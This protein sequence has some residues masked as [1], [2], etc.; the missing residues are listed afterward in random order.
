MHSYGDRY[1][2][3]FFINRDY[4]DVALLDRMFASLRAGPQAKE[5]LRKTLA[6]DEDLF[7]KAL[8]KLWIHKGVV[9]D[10]AENVVRGEESWRASYLLQGEQK[11]AQIDQMMRFAE[12][13]SCR[14]NSLVRHF[15][16]T[17]TGASACGLCDFCA[18]V[19]CVAQRFRTATDTE[20]SALSRVL[21][22]LRSS[23]MK[24][25]GKL[26]SELFPDNEMSRDEFEEVLGA[27]ARAQLLT[28]DDAVFEKDGRQI[29]Y[30]TVSL[31]PAGRTLEESTP[32]Q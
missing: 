9:L 3:D 6:V 29:P 23:P 20:R 26:H 25:T 18:P 31:T 28:F 17:S 22:T 12:S 14:M 21:R 8:E 4:P 24:S 30:R 11:R 15:G 13:N 1:T 2:H 7:D 16:D 10:F 27:M 19:R 32:V 5:Q